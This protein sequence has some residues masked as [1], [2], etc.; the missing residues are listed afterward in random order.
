MAAGR[1]TVRNDSSKKDEDLGRIWRILQRELNGPGKLLGY[2]ALHGKTSRKILWLKIWRSNSD[3]KIVGRWYLE[4]LRDQNDCHNL[5]IDKGTETGDM[6]TI[7]A[8]LMSE[9]GIEDPVASVV[10]GPS[11]SNQI[12]RWWRELHERLELYFREQLQYLKEN[13]F[14]NSQIELYRS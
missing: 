8:F 13:M 2:R 6:A 9:L 11:T 5:R 1:I 4:Y 12:E 7:H 3:P 10:Y 14:Y